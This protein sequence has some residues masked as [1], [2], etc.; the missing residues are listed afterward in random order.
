MMM[1]KLPL[2]HYWAR[3]ALS[4]LALTL[5]AV[6]LT[7]RNRPPNPALVEFLGPPCDVPCWHGLRVGETTYPETL[8]YL[9]GHPWVAGLQERPNRE[10]TWAWAQDS[11]HGEGGGTAEFN[12][13]V[14]TFV[15]MSTGASLGDL[16]GVVGYADGR[17]HIYA[18]APMANPISGT[19]QIV[20]GV[21]H[22]YYADFRLE[23][24]YTCA[25]GAYTM[26]RSPTYLRLGHPHPEY[27]GS[28]LP[29][30]GDDACTWR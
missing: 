25:I 13:G 12:Q 22:E 7:N 9:Q 30:Y 28:P 2:F 21:R 5:L 20:G 3:L 11:A 4:L 23:T 1:H 17:V 10:I 14:L 29:M 24:P 27:T 19:P 8:T 18:V 26:Y 15:E 16:I 6:A